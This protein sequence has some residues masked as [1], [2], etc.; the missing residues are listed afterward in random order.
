MTGTFYATVKFTG[1]KEGVSGASL[2]ESRV[3]KAPNTF[4]GCA[5]NGSG[6]LT[7][8][9]AETVAKTLRANDPR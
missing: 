3:E 8:S 4:N 1:A 9:I 7:S 5:S 6:H 2:F